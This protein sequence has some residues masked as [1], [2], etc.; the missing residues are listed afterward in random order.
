MSSY[1][2]SL[3]RKDSYPI[4]TSEIKIHQPATPDNPTGSPRGGHDGRPRGGRGPA[5]DDGRRRSAARAGAA[6][7]RVGRPVAVD[8]SSAPATQDEDGQ[9]GQDGGGSEQVRLRAKYI[10]TIMILNQFWRLK[11]MLTILFQ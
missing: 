5:G 7:V 11:Q 1:L 3:L 9:D 2:F 4:L 10:M 6:A 8:A